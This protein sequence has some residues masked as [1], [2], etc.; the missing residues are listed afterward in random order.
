MHRRPPTSACSSVAQTF[1]TRS[2]SLKIALLLE[3]SSKNRRILSIVD[4]EIRDIAFKVL[5]V[6]GSG[7]EPVAP[8]FW[9]IALPCGTPSKFQI[10]SL[11]K[12]RSLAR[13]FDFFDVL[14]MFVSSEIALRSRH[15]QNFFELSSSKSIKMALPRETIRF[16]L[17]F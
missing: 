9:K 13:Q 17:T 6:E 5:L 2:C 3:T 4:Q 15:P 12:L 14:M 1:G 11:Q 7:R 8:R 16:F 10:L